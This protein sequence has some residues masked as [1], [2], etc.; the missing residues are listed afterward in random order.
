RSLAIY[1]SIIIALAISG[2]PVDPTTILLISIVDS[3]SNDVTTTKD[4]APRQI[5]LALT[6]N[7][8]DMLVNWIT[9]DEITQPVVYYY[10]GDCMWDTD[11]D[12]EDDSKSSSSSSSSPS[13]SSASHS[14]SNSKS[15]SKAEK[16]KRN[17]D[18]KMTMG[19]TKTYYPYKGYLHSVKLQ[20]LSSGVGYCYRVGGNFVPTADA[21]SWSKWRS[22]RTA[23]NREQPVVFAAF[24][25][26]GTTGNIVPNIRALAAEDDVNLVL[27]AGDLSYGLEETKWDVFGDLVE[28][29][30]S[31]KPFMVVPG[32]WDVKPGGIN[33]FVNRY[34]MPLVYPTPITS[35]TKNVT[36]G[37]YLVS[38]QRNLFYSF[39]Y[40]HAYVIMLSSYDPYEAGSLQYEWF[41]K[42]L[43][44]ANTMRHQYPW[45]IVVFHSPM[46]SSSKGHDGSDLKFRAAME[47]LLHEA[48]VDLAISGHDHC[49]ERSFAVYDGDIIDSNPSLYTSGKGT[50][51]VLAGT[52]GADQDP[53]LDRPE[54][55]AHRENSAGYS[56]IRLTPNLLEFEYTRMNG[57][58]GDSF[59]IA[60]DRSGQ[61]GSTHFGLIALVIFLLI[62]IFPIC[63]YTGLPS[64]IF[65]LIMLDPYNSRSLTR[66]Q[67]V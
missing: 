35:L 54:W 15:N 22:F 48:Q 53:W 49:Y 63:A 25:D 16:K 42:Q 40:T 1:N 19:T 28:P 57:T 36:S 60:K 38:T 34:P 41:K 61:V 30:T 65:N 8:N 13:S 9:K 43:D 37:E 18:I 31:S 24:A 39:E 32:N 47:Q 27:H 23:P 50:I 3:N 29:V 51:H 59:K 10:I 45:L 67:I 11:S 58:I 55:T 4:I 26:S 44:R 5:N 46:Y 56:L 20:H 17:T 12:D 21:T 7:A 14:K 64:K 52:A 33:A 2:L 62:L 66:R 6:Y